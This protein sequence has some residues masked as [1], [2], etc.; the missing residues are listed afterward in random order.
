MA[1]LDAKGLKRKL[2]DKAGLQCER[3]VLLC[4]GSNCRP[5]VASK[6][7]KSLGKQ[8]KECEKRGRLF[9]RTEVKCLKLCRNGPIALVYPEG[10]YYQGVTPE[11]CERIVQEHL[12]AGCPVA[13]CAFATV[14][15]EPQPQFP[16]E[17]PGSVQVL[18]PI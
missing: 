10:T 1:Q 15:L 3:H 2:K 16:E 11:V 18:A 5:D 8:F 13:E 14:P 7:W 4:T 9:H 6:A 17:P 12:V